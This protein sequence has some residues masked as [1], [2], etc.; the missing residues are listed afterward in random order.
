MGSLLDILASIIALLLLAHMLYVA[1]HELP[2]HFWRAVE[3]FGRT[4]HRLLNWL[5]LKFRR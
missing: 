1:S 2:R 4:R 5:D 3:S